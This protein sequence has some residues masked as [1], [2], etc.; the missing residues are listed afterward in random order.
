MHLLQ[1]STGENRRE[2]RIE[3][4]R[5]PEFD[6]LPKPASPRPHCVC[7]EKDGARVA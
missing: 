7:L 5:K 3:R 2:L 4:N 6:S 1:C